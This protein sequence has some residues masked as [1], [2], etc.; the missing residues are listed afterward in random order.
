[1]LRDQPVWDE[2]DTRCRTGSL[3]MRHT[4]V[5]WGRPR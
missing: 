4:G 2:E 5:S 1:V 3:F